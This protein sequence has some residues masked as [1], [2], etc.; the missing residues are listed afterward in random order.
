MY[1]I[2][3]SNR[4]YVDSYLM[5]ITTF[6]KIP[7][8][9]KLIKGYFNDD[10]VDVDLTQ[11]SPTI[12]N[13]IQRNLSSKIIG[14]LELYSKSQYPSNKK[15][16][17]TYLFKPF[18]NCYP[19]F[20][21]SSSVKH[22]YKTNILV[23]IKYLSWTDT[24]PRGELLTI[25]GSINDFLANEEA[26]ID[27]YNLHTKP[28]QLDSINYLKH[29]TDTDRITINL[30]IYSIDPV[31]CRDIDD[32]L[33]Y[34]YINDGIFVLYIHI[35]DVYSVLKEINYLENVNNYSS[36]YY[37]NSDFTTKIKPMLPSNISENIASLLENT[38]R[39]MLSLQIYYDMN[40]NKIQSI[41]FVKTKGI[42][43]KNY[44][45]DNIPLEFKELY[46]LIEDIYYKYTGT[47]FIINSDSHKFI[48]CL[49]L[50]YNHTFSKLILEPNNNG[51][52]RS[53]TSTYVDNIPEHLK[54]LYRDA[55][56]YV[57]TT[58]PHTILGLSTYT[59]ASSP[60]RR[61]VDLINQ[62]IYHKQ[63]DFNKKS[64]LDINDYQKRLKRFYNDC[65]LLELYS[66]LQEY[67][68]IIYEVYI[69]RIKSDKNIMYLY[70][71]E[72]KTLVRIN[73]I[74]PKLKHLY[75]IDITENIL[76]ITDLESSLLKIYPLYKLIMCKFS[77][78]DKP[79]FIDIN[80]CI[81]TELLLKNA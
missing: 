36:I 56:K 11:S 26:R 75:S 64:L 14:I 5:D 6:D 43:T 47:P 10:I 48:E 40:S 80:H 63:F 9:S 72:L 23:S 22:K 8:E 77:C 32:A 71:Q 45:Y 69:V 39:K 73:I 30:P 78:Y 65:R 46:P 74:H 67:N 16:I 41:S 52:Y 1:H 7:I 76:K 54:F 53:A 42:I 25:Y 79:D 58:E 51:I 18:N 31:G 4:T 66:L 59:H 27:H 2:V 24:I 35:A 28:I 57:S 12:L 62:S 21:V 38:E 33:S 17:P 3:I 70:I 55:A 34:D 19:Y 61:I 81:L 37:K 15:G 13:L 60:L 68:S 20:L 29:N 49:M 44:N 50:L